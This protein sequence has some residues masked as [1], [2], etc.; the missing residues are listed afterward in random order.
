[1]DTDRLTKIE[2]YIADQEQQ[3]QDLSDMV[4]KQWDEIEILKR[5]LSRTQEK[6]KTVE[7]TANAA[8]KSGDATSVSEFAAMEKPPHY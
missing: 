3:I 6:L 7:D 5:R 4:T 8:T 1:M 2:E